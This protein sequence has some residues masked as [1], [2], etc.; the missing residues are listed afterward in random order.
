MPRKNSLLMRGSLLAVSFV[1][2][3]LCG[4]MPDTKSIAFAPIDTDG[5]ARTDTLMYT[6]APLEGEKRSGISLLLH[7]EGYAYANLSL[8]ITIQQD[9][10]LL[11]NEQRHYLLCENSPK[12]GIGRRCD[13]ILP[14]DNF[15][16]CDTLPTI[17]T[18]TQQLDVPSLAG[19]QRVG[20]H[21]GRPIRKPGEPIWRVDW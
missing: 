5:W 15:T 13:Y 2:T 10:C 17:V 1:L 11:Y 6:I 18:L 21:V 7:T 20:V 9:S 12:P 4:C 3:F 14:I 19:I 16:L 8:D